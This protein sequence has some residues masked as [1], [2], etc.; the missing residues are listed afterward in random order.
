VH[1]AEYNNVVEYDT[2]L[3]QPATDNRC[4]GEE[5]R[6][7]K[8]GSYWGM[9]L[10]LV[11]THTHTPFPPLYST[12]NTHSTMPTTHDIARNQRYLLGPPTEAGWVDS[13]PVS[14]K[15]VVCRVSYRHRNILDLVQIYRLGGGGSVIRVGYCPVLCIVIIVTISSV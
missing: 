13:S 12:L 1:M 2:S 5:E 11:H 7:G 9:L 3:D 6:E 4:A 14:Y 10:L 15:L 8:Q